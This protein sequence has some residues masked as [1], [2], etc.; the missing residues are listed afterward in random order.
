M[1]GVKNTQEFI[2]N[3][4]SEINTQ[5]TRL[6]GLRT[7]LANA[8]CEIRNRSVATVNRVTHA[9]NGLCEIP[10][11]LDVQTAPLR[12]LELDE[13]KRYGRQMIV[14]EIGLSGQLRLKS[15]SVLVVGVGGL[16]CPAAA[17]LA[18]AGVGKIGLIDDDV[19]ETSNLHRQI[20]HGVNTIGSSKVLSAI[21]SLSK[22]N[23]LV[24]YVPHCETLTCSNA[25]ECFSEYDCILDC[26][27]Q[28]SSRYLISDFAVLLGKPL[29]SASA[30]RSEGQLM[31]LNQP[32]LPRG[33]PDGGPCYRCVFP[34]PPPADS[35]ITCGEGGI[36]GP[37]VGVMGVLQALD[38]I[39]LLT[40]PPN[41]L[42]NPPSLL[43]FSAF[44]FRPFRTVKLRNRRPDCIAC[45]NTSSTQLSG[46]SFD[47]SSFCGLK[48]VVDILRPE[49]RVSAK[50]YDRIRRNSSS[51][52][53]LIDVREK[54]HFNI[55]HL[56]GSINIPM[57][58]ITSPSSKEVGENDRVNQKDEVAKI[59]AERLPTYIICRLGNDSQ[60]AVSWI[61]QA[62]SKD[63][64][65]VI[66][67]DI[68]GGF[69]SWR[70]EVDASWPD[71]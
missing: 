68:Q 64:D 67:A 5:E 32:P 7:Q 28:P 43:L 14:P 65:G 37:V 42:P 23:P 12:P 59:I 50:A 31:V 25:A 24:T 11:P 30:L 45:S 33:N 51:M 39:K 9:S 18:G 3:L 21:Q 27:D 22:L 58:L 62:F 56:P 63:D 4:R 13:F 10:G 60:L 17:Y 16:G 26:T 49:E 1:E 71:Y 40:A 41:V 35:V 47:Y 44:S 36:L 70:K 53:H 15:A 52:H 66:V 48:S 2:E 61:K 38:V 6:A 69:E 19:V 29:V 54:V 57:S 55:C 34:K 46:G 20:L 8:E